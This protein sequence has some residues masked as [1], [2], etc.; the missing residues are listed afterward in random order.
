[1]TFSVWWRS[2][3]WSNLHPIYLHMIFEKSSLKTLGWMNLI[4]C[5]FQTWILQATQAVKVKFKL[6]KKSSSSNLIFQIWFFKK[7][8]LEYIQLRFCWVSW[9]YAESLYESSQSLLRIR[10]KYSQLS[11][12]RVLVYYVFESTVRVFC[13]VFVPAESLMR[14]CIKKI[15]PKLN[16]VGI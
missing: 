6:D 9:K 16:Y 4:F 7:S 11:N 10:W 15:E 13:W 14:V 1:M 5:L 3:F 8:F 2:G 12:K